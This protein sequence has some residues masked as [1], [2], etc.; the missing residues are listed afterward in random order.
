MGAPPT[1]YLRRFAAA[2]HLASLH[3]GG[4]LEPLYQLHACRLKLLDA[5]PMDSTPVAPAAAPAARPGAAAV[6]EEAVLTAVGRYCFLAPGEED[7]PGSRGVSPH[8]QRQRSPAASNGGDAATVAAAL[9]GAAAAGGANGGSP[10]APRHSPESP[11]QPSAATAE[12]LTAT[13]GDSQPPPT[14]E[15]LLADL[16][17]DCVRALHFV[18]DSN[19]HFHRARYRL[20]R[21]L[22]LQTCSCVATQVVGMSEAEPLLVYWCTGVLMYWCT[23]VLVYHHLS[24]S[25]L[26]LRHEWRQAWLLAHQTFAFAHTH[27]QTRSRDSRALSMLQGEAGRGQRGGGP[28]GDAAAVHPQPRRLRHQHGGDLRQQ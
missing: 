11:T 26:L 22:S 15:Q 7:L 6:A 25:T 13:S 10:P 1:E 19:R 2:S 9:G 17:A 23:G 16:R 3:A 24:A 28:G 4:L 8:V 12:T 5:L 21:C 27:V 20:A 18:L 14:L